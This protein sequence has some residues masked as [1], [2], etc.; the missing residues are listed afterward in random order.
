MFSFIFTI[1]T[2]LSNLLIYILLLANKPAGP[3]SAMAAFKQMDSLNPGAAK[4]K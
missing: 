2:K 4:P 1:V 3:K